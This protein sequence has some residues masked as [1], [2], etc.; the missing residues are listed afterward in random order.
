MRGGKK[1]GRGKYYYDDGVFYD[2]QW[3]EDE[4]NGFGKLHYDNE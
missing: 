1:E 4:I 2:G 3:K